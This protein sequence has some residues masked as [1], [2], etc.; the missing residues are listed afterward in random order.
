MQIEALRDLRVNT[1]AGEEIT[2]PTPNTIPFTELHRIGL[3][4]VGGVGGRERFAWEAPEL[5]LRAASTGAHDFPRETVEDL[6]STEPARA[7]PLV[8]EYLATVPDSGEAWLAGARAATALGA[9]G[10]ARVY[11]QKAVAFEP[12]RPGVGEL[13][14]EL[15]VRLPPLTARDRL[16]GWLLQ[17]RHRIHGPILDVGTSRTERTWLDRLGVRVT[18]DACEAVYNG[19][20]DR[21][22]LVA[23]LEDLSLIPDQTFGTVVCT[24]VLEHVAHPDVALSEIRRVLRPDGVLL[25]SVP[26]FYP[27]HP[28][29]LDLRRFT[30]QGLV[31]AVEEAGFQE[32]VGGGL[33]L[34]TAARQHL[35]EAVKL[36]TGRSHCPNEKSLA[37]SN[38]TLTATAGDP[39]D[40]HPPRAER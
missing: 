28:C 33:Q 36:M 10:D 37:F 22:D 38:W 21:P 13:A 31:F 16:E 14:R 30:L 11:L 19:S 24:E 23:D 7:L 9:V 12:T 1:P 25:L 35:V 3:P 4:V 29:P 5:I 34:P 8:V 27:F 2:V 15:G 39:T 26:W 18:L 20:N 32:V 17:Q 40:A 6:L